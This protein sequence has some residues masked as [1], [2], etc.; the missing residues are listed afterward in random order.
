MS[1]LCPARHCRTRHKFTTIYWTRT[2]NL[3]HL[4]PISIENIRFSESEYPKTSRNILHIHFC[5]PTLTVLG[6]TKYSRHSRHF[7]PSN[8]R[9]KLVITLTI[10]AIIDLG[11]ISLHDLVYFEARYSMFCYRLSSCGYGSK[12]R[13]GKVQ[14]LTGT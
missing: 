14:S 9:V 2:W 11:N 12:S 7:M 13:F 4:E 10:K 3:K 8:L 1:V 6:H 5:W